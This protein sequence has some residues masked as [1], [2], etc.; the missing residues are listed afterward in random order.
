ML[1]SET[2][3]YIPLIQDFTWCITLCKVVYFSLLIALQNNVYYFYSFQL[4]IFSTTQ[5]GLLRNISIIS[6]SVTLY[7]S[8]GIDIDIL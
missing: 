2:Q 5:Y 3:E 8:I 7:M 6:C 4:Y 1:N